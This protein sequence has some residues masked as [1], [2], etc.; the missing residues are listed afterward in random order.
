VIGYTIWVYRAFA[1]KV[2]PGQDY[3]TGNLPDRV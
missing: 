3:G 1:G 2:K